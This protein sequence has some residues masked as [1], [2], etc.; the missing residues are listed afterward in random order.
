MLDE[1][2]KIKLSTILFLL[3]KTAYF[4]KFFANILDF[5]YI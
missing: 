4:F 3:S 2:G 5:I 1:R